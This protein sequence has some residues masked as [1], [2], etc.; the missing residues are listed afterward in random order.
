VSGRRDYSN[1]EIPWATI[2]TWRHRKTAHETALG[3]IL[4]RIV[5]D[6]LGCWLW[7]GNLNAQGYGT[8]T[9]W[10]YGKQLAHRLVWMVLRG[11]MPTGLEPDHLCRVRRCVNPD[12]LEWVTHRENILRGEAPAARHARVTHCPRGH[13]YTPANTSMDGGSRMCRECNRRRAAMNRAKA[14]GTLWAA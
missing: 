4:A 10:R 12:H 7:T 2:K 14:K 13:E 9:Y 3:Y 6:E 1:D 5:R 11:T 8:G